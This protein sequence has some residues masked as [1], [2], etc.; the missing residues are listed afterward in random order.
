MGSWISQN[1]KQDTEDGEFSL[2][3]G[4]CRI[5]SNYMNIIDE[6][7]SIILKYHKSAKWSNIHKGKYIILA[8]DDAKAICDDGVEDD[9]TAIGYGNSIRADFC[10]KRGQS[11]SWEFECKIIHSVGNFFGV[12]RCGARYKHNFSECPASGLYHAYG[13]DD[14][15]NRIY[16]GGD[17]TTSYWMKPQFPLKEIFIIKVIADW[18]EKECK[19]TFY[20]NGAKLNEREDYTMKLPALDDNAEF[21]P[22]VTPFNK[23]AY[24][25]IH[26]V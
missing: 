9:F 16:E 20:Y 23:G 15:K 3:S 5:E 7:I 25:T 6:I 21:Y 18:T 2:I 19:L 26:Y 22:C 13:L 14:E 12:I 1:K 8:E 10:I 24:C 4:Y 11:I 17:R